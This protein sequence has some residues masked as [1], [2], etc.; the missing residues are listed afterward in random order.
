MPQL[1]E[2]GIDANELERR[3]KLQ[4]YQANDYAYRFAERT[5][6]LQEAEMMKPTSDI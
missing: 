2:S 5:M 4:T 3:F 1:R 6:E